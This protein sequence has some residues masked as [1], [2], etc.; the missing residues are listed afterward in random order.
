MIISIKDFVDYFF[1]IE[2][3]CNNKSAIVDFSVH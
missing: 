3:F 2:V 1:G